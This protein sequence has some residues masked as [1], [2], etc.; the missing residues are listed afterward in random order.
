MEKVTPRMRLAAVIRARRTELKYSQDTFAD[1]IDMHRAYYASIERGERNVT[2][3]TLIRVATGLRVD[4][5]TL[6]RKANI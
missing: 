1:V 2:I 5:A 4:V 6:A 3:E